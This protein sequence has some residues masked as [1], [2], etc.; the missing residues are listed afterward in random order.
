MHDPTTVDQ[1]G[2][3]RGSQYRSAIFYT[4][5]EQ[6]RVAEAVK[7]RVDASGQWSSPVVTQIVSASAFTPAEDYHQDYLEKNPG[8]YTCHFLRDPVY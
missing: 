8:G 1:Q 6:R 2:H 4:S 5:E 3:D 7:N